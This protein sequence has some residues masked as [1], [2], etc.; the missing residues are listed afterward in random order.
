MDGGSSLSSF[1]MYAQF[2][3][4]KFRRLSPLWNRWSDDSSR[5]RSYPT[6]MEAARGGDLL[7]RWVAH[8]FGEILLHGWTHQREAGYGMVSY[9]TN[10]SDE[11][12][13][14]TADETY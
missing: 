9:L 4:M 1:T 11:F 3:R 14:L 10:R 6:G 5:R 2:T 13:G 12:T 8:Q 7:Y